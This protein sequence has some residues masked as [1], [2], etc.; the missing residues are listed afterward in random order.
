MLQETFSPVAN[1]QFADI[2]FT[3]EK[4]NQQ[5]HV[6]NQVTQPNTPYGG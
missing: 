2:P 5:L 1:V 3:M 4:Q 6:V